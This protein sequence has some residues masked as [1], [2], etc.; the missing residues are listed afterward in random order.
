M[1]MAGGVAVA[2]V[3]YNQP[4]LGLIERSYPGST[5]IGLIPTATQLGYAVGL[6]LLVPLGDL[7]E[8]RSAIV[9]QF[10]LLAGALV[11]AALAPTT[12]TLIAASLILGVAAT[13][14]QQIVPFAAILA[15]P[16]RRGAIVGTVVSGLLGGILLSRTV[17]GFVG[18]H[19]GW[20]EMFW[21]GVPLAL[22][23]ALLMHLTLPRSRPTDTIKYSDALKSLL[24]MWREEPKLRRATLTQA[25]LFASFT[26]FWTVLSLRLL[27]PAFGLGSDVAGIFGIIGAAGIFAAPLAGRIAD[28]RGPHLVVSLSAIGTLA[29][30][31]V[32][33]LWGSLAGLVLGV[34][35]LDVG[36]N[37]ALVSNQHQIFAL[38]PEG[39]SRLNT[40]FMAGMFIGGSLG[41]LGATAS[42]HFGGWSAVCGY[43]GL[44][45]VIAILMQLPLPALRVA[46]DR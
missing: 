17:A 41:S 12:T 31:I 45:A 22:L 8:R 30:W 2:N 26:V 37:A 23:A 6:F 32:F 39:R 1:A 35:I 10:L 38:R 3:Y 7:V 25:A 19:L 43:G 40:L 16:E 4:L 28:R 5:A 33:G 18:A 34:I 46:E 15:P 44:L 11:F 29:S 14:A 42:Y 9:L 13:V 21:I 20:R 27:E 36:V 24:H